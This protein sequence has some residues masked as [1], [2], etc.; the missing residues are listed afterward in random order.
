VPWD[1]L[2]PLSVLEKIL[3]LPLALQ[4]SILTLTEIMR[5]SPSLL[6]PGLADTSGPYTHRLR[7]T[8]IH[9][10]IDTEKRAVHVMDVRRIPQVPPAFPG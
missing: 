9:M 10:W 5:I 3:A 6:Q 4:E 1:I 8:A 7:D 2:I